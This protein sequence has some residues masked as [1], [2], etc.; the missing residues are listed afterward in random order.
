MLDHSRE[1]VAHAFI[2]STQEAEAGRFLSSKLAW[3]TKWV[4]RQPG[5]H[6][7]KPCLKK[8]KT[9]KQKKVGSPISYTVKPC[10]RFMHPQVQ[11]S[12]AF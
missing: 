5:L 6:T 8:Q 12:Q 3:S 2:P 9:N 7:E 11:V 1:V 10:P 4:P